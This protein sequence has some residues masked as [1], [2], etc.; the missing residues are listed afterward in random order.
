MYVT[1]TD[2]QNIKKKHYLTLIA[3]MLSMIGPFS[4]DTYLPSFPEIEANFNVSRALLTQSMSVYLIAFA[5]STLIWGPI[6][7]RI[8]RRRVIFSGL[9]IYI[10]ASI[11]CAYSN[12][13]NSFLIFRIMQ[14][15]AAS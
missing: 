15:L 14:G 3:A 1:T 10:L 9:L 13:L 2:T 6:S 11:G 5:V 8:G 4:I 12:D 7:D